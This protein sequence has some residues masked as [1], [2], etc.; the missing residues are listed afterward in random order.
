M[1]LVGLIYLIVG[2]CSVTTAKPFCC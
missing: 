1:H 2:F